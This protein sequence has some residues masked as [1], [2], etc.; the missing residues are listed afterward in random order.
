MSNSLAP[1]RRAVHVLL[2][3]VVLAGFQLTLDLPEFESEA[4][5]II[6]EA[7]SEIESLCARLDVV[8]AHQIPGISLP[9]EW[10]SEL[11]LVSE[12]AQARSL[13]LLGQLQSI[14]AL[15]VPD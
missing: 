14:R 13:E 5:S 9:V 7:T 8:D 12:R 6:R 1:V 2:N 4:R 3:D 10:K 11:R 15:R